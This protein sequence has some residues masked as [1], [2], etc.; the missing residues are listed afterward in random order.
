MSIV[1][2]RVDDET[3]RQV[4]EIFEDMGLDLSTAVRMFFR[5]II[6]E[7]RIPLNLSYEVPNETTLASLRESE[8]IVADPGAPRF[9]DADE[10]FQALGI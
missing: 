9:R 4:N 1:T 5:Q 6:R 7:Q 2:I 10:M 3:K 8:Q